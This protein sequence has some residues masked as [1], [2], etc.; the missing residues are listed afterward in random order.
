MHD[1]LSSPSHATLLM[2][3]G[4]RTT[5]EHH[6]TSRTPCL[7][8]QDHNIRFQPVPIST[9]LSS[10][11]GFQRKPVTLTYCRLCHSTKP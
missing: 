2:T 5:G 1:L 6:P 3:C 8:G 4:Q 11:A 7:L 10:T 9:T